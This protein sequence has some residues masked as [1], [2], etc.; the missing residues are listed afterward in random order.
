MEK[1]LS[2]KREEFLQRIITAVNES[3]LPPCVALDVMKGV[4]EEV[5]NLAR[6]QYEADKKAY[7]EKEATEDA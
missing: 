3:D 6:R 5:A 4:T 1:P 2:I 7:A